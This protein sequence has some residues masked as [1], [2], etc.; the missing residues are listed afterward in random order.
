MATSKILVKRLTNESLNLNSV[1][2]VVGIQSVVVNVESGNVQLKGSVG[3]KFGN[4]I[5]TDDDYVLL[6]ADNTPYTIGLGNVDI[7]DLRLVCSEG[8]YSVHGEVVSTATGVTN[9]F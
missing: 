7:Q 3:V 5:T 9:D 6:T 8:V 4:K 2:N 1:N